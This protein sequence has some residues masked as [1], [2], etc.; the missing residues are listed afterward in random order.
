MQIVSA[1]PQSNG[2]SKEDADLLIE[3]LKCDISVIEE[4]SKEYGYGDQWAQFE[5]K[6]KQYVDNA[7]KCIASIN[8]DEEKFTEYVSIH[9]YDHIFNRNSFLN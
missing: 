1:A 9:I 3:V 4:V 7:K 2:V 5:S 8:G 6:F